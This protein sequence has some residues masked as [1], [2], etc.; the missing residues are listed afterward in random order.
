MTQ[1]L[2]DQGDSISA[3]RPPNPGGSDDV[4]GACHENDRSAKGIK[5]QAQPAASGVSGAR[6][7]SLRSSRSVFARVS[8]LAMRMLMRASVWCSRAS[9]ASMYPFGG[10]RF[11]DGPKKVHAKS[12]ECGVSLC[13]RYW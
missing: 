8:L 2:L 4:S 5:D 1:G 3:V 11:L 13:S 7:T 12:D 6:P 9:I 10:P